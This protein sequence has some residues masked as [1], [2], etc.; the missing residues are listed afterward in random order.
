MANLARMLDNLRYH[1]SISNDT[2]DL[3]RQWVL[4]EVTLFACRDRDVDTT[5]L[6]SDDF[7]GLHTLF[8]EVDLARIGRVDLDGGDC[9]GNLDFEGW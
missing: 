5:S 8:R 2:L 9:T 1:L 6:G 7:D 3:F 4:L